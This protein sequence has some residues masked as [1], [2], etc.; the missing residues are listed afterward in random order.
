M[1]YCLGYRSWLIFANVSKVKVKNIDYPLGNNNEW[2]SQRGGHLEVDFTQT[3]GHLE[4]D[5]TQ[6]SGHLEVDFTQ[7]SEP[8]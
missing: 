6:T 5:F 1:R 4:E 8:P 3:S 2:I 7:R